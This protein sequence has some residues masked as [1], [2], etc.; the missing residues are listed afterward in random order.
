MKVLQISIT[1]GSDCGVALFA[2]VLQE[3]LGR[4][5]IEIETVHEPRGSADADLVLLQ[6]HD[7]LIADDAVIALARSSAAPVVL[8][9][10]T[11]RNRGLYDHVDGLVSMCPGMIGRTTK[12]V[13]TYLDPAWTPDRLEDRR[14]LR[15]EFALPQDR[16]VVGTNGYLRFERQFLEV[17]EA[18]LPAARRNDWFIDMITSPWRLESPGLVE[19]L[20]RLERQHPSHFRFG[21]TFLDWRT[22]NRRLQA[23]DLLWCWTAAPSVPYASGVLSDQYGS[24]TRI[25]A[26]DKEQHRPVLQLPNVVAGPPDLE[27]FVAGL[28]AEI[29]NGP[30]PRHDPSP[31]SWDNCIDDVAAFLR[32]VARSGK[33]RPGL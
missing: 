18:L 1:R 7:D 2:D 12:P 14:D 30:H 13:L 8:F 28:V 31:V 4:I 23:C 21:H 32:S 24:G 16:T 3:R 22:L 9:A 10:H 26:V 29:G 20:Q 6:H 15:R 5:G 11:D 17:A 27:A 25:F 19:S 33:G